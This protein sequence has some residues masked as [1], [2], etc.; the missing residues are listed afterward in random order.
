MKAV[1]ARGGTPKPDFESDI[2]ELFLPG[3]ALWVRTSTVDPQKGQLFDVFNAEGDFLDSFFVP[4][5]DKILGVVDDVIF[6]QE[7]AEDGT[8]SIVL[9]KNTERAGLPAPGK[10]P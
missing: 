8:I 9:H 10:R 7:T 6:V 1:F 3:D 4:V 2:L 5:Q